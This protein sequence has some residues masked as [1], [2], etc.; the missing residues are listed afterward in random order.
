[1]KPDNWNKMKQKEKHKMALEL[2]GSFRGH[3]IISQALSIA[4][5]QLNKV[6]GVHKELSNI[7]DMEMLYEEIFPIY[8]IDEMT[9]K[10]VKKLLTKK[11]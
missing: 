5:R 1:M 10:Q 3:Y 2:L 6:K 9:P 4:I 11:N 7:Q 8:K